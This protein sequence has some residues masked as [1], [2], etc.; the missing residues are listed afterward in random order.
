MIG[1]VLVVGV[2]ALSLA[3]QVGAAP[4]LNKDVA[5]ILYRNCVAC[6]RPADIAPMSLMD[7]QSARPWAKAIREAVLAR[8]MPPWFADPHWGSFSNDTRLSTAEIETITAWVDGGAKEGDARDLPPAPVFAE[9]W[10]LGRPD[11]VIDIGEDFVVAPGLDAYEHFTV[12][13]R[14]TEGKW[15]RAA[16]IRRGN[17]RVVH[18]VHVNLVQDD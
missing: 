16:E 6:H 4:T 17:R 11:I 9:G 3:S 12:P 18:H 2:L 1:R 13:T 8:K 10:R 5:P 15:I 14:L 7:Y